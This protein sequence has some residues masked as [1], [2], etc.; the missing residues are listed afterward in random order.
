MS[1][2]RHTARAFWHLSAMEGV[3]GEAVSQS[4]SLAALLRLAAP[5]GNQA[6]QMA[7]KA[8]KRLSEDP[9]VTPVPSL[10]HLYHFAKRKA[11]PQALILLHGCS[12]ALASCI[13]QVLDVPV[14][15]S[16]NLGSW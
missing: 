10:I 7:R 8:L 11:H 9:A 16:D 1:L 2:Q 4:D 5:E 14:G 13:N 15:H 12:L 3:V 6:S